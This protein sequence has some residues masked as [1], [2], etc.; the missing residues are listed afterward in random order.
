M[1]PPAGLIILIRD[2]AGLLCWSVV[3]ELGGR[4]AGLFTF[5]IVCP[6]SRVS[7]RPL[8]AKHRLDHG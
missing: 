6:L 1:V 3:V 5:G 7:E 2:I 8:Q 4:E